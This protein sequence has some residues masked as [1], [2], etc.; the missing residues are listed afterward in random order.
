MSASTPIPLQRLGNGH[1]PQTRSLRLPLHGVPATRWKQLEHLLSSTR[2]DQSVILALITAGFG[3]TDLA[4]HLVDALLEQLQQTQ[5]VSAAWI[6][7]VR[8]ALTDPREVWEPAYLSE[9]ARLRVHLQTHP[10]PLLRG[11]YLALLRPW[12][13]PPRRWQQQW[14][15][16]PASQQTCWP[17]LCEARGEPLTLHRDEALGRLRQQWQ[18]WFGARLSRPLLA[19]CLGRAQ[20][21]NRDEPGVW[22]PLLAIDV[23]REHGGGSS[24][25][26]AVLVRTHL[27]TP[28]PR[29][30]RTNPLVCCLLEIAA[31]ARCDRPDAMCA[32][33]S[34]APMRAAALCGLLLLQPFQPPAMLRQG[35]ARPEP[36]AGLAGGST[37]ERLPP[38]L[39]VPEET[40]VATWPPTAGTQAGALTAA[41]APRRWSA[42]GTVYGAAAV[43]AGPPFVAHRSGGLRP[44]EARTTVAARFTAEVSAHWL[45]VSGSTAADFNA[46]VQSLLHRAGVTIAERVHPDTAVDALFERGDALLANTLQQAEVPLLVHQLLAHASRTTRIYLLAL[47]LSRLFARIQP[48]P[49]DDPAMRQAAQWMVSV[50]AGFRAQ[51]SH[52]EVRASVDTGDAAHWLAPP[53]NNTTSASPL[54][55]AQAID[56]AWDAEFR[57]EPALAWPYGRLQHKHSGR[58]AQPLATADLPTLALADVVLGIA[59]PLLEARQ[60]GYTLHLLP[61]LSA[62]HWQQHCA[63]YAQTQALL[64]APSCL[65]VTWHRVA[66]QL[67]AFAQQLP[68]IDA[69]DASLHLRSRLRGLILPLHRA[70]Q[71][72]E[73]RC[74]HL[75]RHARARRNVRGFLALV[76]RHQRLHAMDATA[77]ADAVHAVLPTPRAALPAVL[78]HLLDH[79]GFPDAEDL[80]ATVERLYA[81]AATRRLLAQLVGVPS[82]RLD[83]AMVHLFFLRLAAAPLGV[84]DRTPTLLQWQRQLTRKAATD[85][86]RGEWIERL[87]P[88]GAAAL[89]ERDDGP[90]LQGLLE[91]ALA[92][93][94]HA[95]HRWALRQQAPQRL[96]AWLESHT[97]RR[98]MADVLGQ[99]GVGLRFL[100]RDRGLPPPLSLRLLQ[101]AVAH[102]LP[103][104]SPDTLASVCARASRSPAPVITLAVMLHTHYPL[105]SALAC[106]THAAVLL[107]DAAP[108]RE[109]P[110]F[111]LRF[112]LPPLPAN[113]SAPALTLQEVFRDCGMPWLE[114]LEPGMP[115]WQ[116]WE[117]LV[118]TAGFQDAAGQLLD[119]V[120]ARPSTMTAL[121][122]QQTV[123]RWLLDHGV[124]HAVVASISAALEGDHASMLDTREILQQQLPALPS[125]MARGVLWWLLVRQAGRPEWCV[126]ELPDGLDYGRSLRSVALLQAVS[127]CEAAVPGAVDALDYSRLV[128]LP[129]RLSPSAAA[130]REDHS[131][132]WLHALVRPALLYAAAHRRITQHGGPARASANETRHA[133]AFVRER[134]AALALAADQLLRPA[135]QRRMLA[136]QQLRDAGVPDP[137]WNRTIEH[138]PVDVLDAAGVTRRPPGATGVGGMSALL[139]A[140]VHAVEDAF[141][142]DTLLEQLV[143]GTV[144]LTGHPS[145]AQLFDQAFALYQQQMTGALAVLL[146]RSLDGLPATDWQMLRGATVTPLLVP[147]AP[148]GIVLR[149]VPPATGQGA[150]SAIHLAVIPS[151]GYAA[152]LRSGDLRVDGQWQSGVLYPHRS[153]VSGTVPARFGPEDHQVLEVARCHSGPKQSVP[154]NGSGD[155]VALLDAMAG[156]MYGDFFIRTRDAELGRLTGGERLQ[157]VEAS[158]ADALARFAIPFYGCGRDLLDGDAA[159]ARVDCTI[160]ALSMMLPEAGLGR[161]LRGTT[162]LVA[163]AGRVSARLLLGD[164]ARVMLRLG[165]DIAAQSGVRLLH[166]LGQGVVRL[167]REGTQWLLDHVPALESRLASTLRHGEE[168]TAGFALDR[169][170]LEETGGHDIVEAGCARVRRQVD[171]GGCTSETITLF[172]YVPAPAFDT[173]GEVGWFAGMQVA[174]DEPLS[175]TGRRFIVDGEFWQQTASHAGYRFTRDSGGTV[176][177]PRQRIRARLVGG[178]SQLVRVELHNPYPDHLLRVEQGAVIGRAD[179]GSRALITRV[180]PGRFYVAPLPAG[181]APLPGQA[182][183][184]WPLEQQGFSAAENDA[185]KTAWWGA[186]HYSQQ[187][188]L[189]GA[190]LVDR[191]GSQLQRQLEQLGDLDRLLQEV[192]AGSPYTFHNLPAQAVMSCAQSNCRYVQALRQQ[193]GP[194]HWRPP[195][196]DD[197]WISD[198]LRDLLNPPG[199]VAR[200]V[201]TTLDDTLEA[202]F[203]TPRRGPAKTLA[204]AE[205]TLQGEP[206]PLVFHATSG[207][208]R[209]K[210]LLPLSNLEQRSAPAGW[211]VDGRNVRTPHARY[212]DAQPSAASITQGEVNT[213]APHHSLH[214]E[215]LDGHLFNERNAR[216]LDAERNLY[217]RI[218]RQITEG[219]LDPTQVT[220]VRLFSSRRIC[221]SC[222]ISVGSLRAR[223][224]EAYFEVVER[225]AGPALD[226]NAAAATQDVA[227]KA[228]LTPRSGRP[229]DAR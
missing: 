11:L 111:V 117:L 172:G 204:M 62:A 129:G 81:R 208:R 1:A 170:L 105:L 125:R 169:R 122:A 20:R 135:P 74:A 163:K 124:G 90:G 108:A 87:S 52:P 130:T 229:A 70:V 142:P 76:H 27:R 184:F 154:A 212:I 187:C 61:Q 220:S 80:E 118:V 102:Y 9:R 92:I 46:G 101:R 10:G 3:G 112:P 19:R 201:F 35:A 45:G 195:R 186:F 137:Y 217:Y 89:F 97:G 160:D 225:Q 205:L 85:V 145:I 47:G 37:T 178:E 77:V 141:N 23:L 221:A 64:D 31:R 150:P 33:E 63:H 107:A 26:E 188:Q 179:D 58:F 192:R 228:P 159:G 181:A 106:L 166:D 2:V 168:R 60:P 175:E 48:R 138:V 54:T 165:E 162:E 119:T 5:P 176:P 134:H 29:T 144:E 202:R 40:D 8:Q 69:S 15:G 218:E 139:D 155:P 67:Q 147:G 68:L 93:P 42:M 146:A 34:P 65:L 190:A 153:F 211:E 72:L 100:F 113:F 164:A 43:P 149:C 120:A 12:S 200:D 99:P 98:R 185:V 128:Q 56:D 194:A 222:H 161:L 214:A 133:L 25:M 49:L 78:S 182:L 88:A 171:I 209:G 66:R 79:S 28:S 44:E 116:A 213:V 82:D 13:L 16:L 177:Q 132:A 207:Q 32:L 14:S 50:E 140:A 115:P 167:G 39:D 24:G 30:Q 152:R 131:A 123:A 226:I 6:G 193:I 114:Q 227:A 94:D 203:L 86:L 83:S 21:L 219:A 189:S 121:T 73:G 158:V 126:A 59:H 180:S 127:L 156:M 223:F 174:S 151:A 191:F 173:P 183:E 143:D 91:D 4:R 199:T 136:A 196:P 197:V 51:V 57:P 148:H 109:I 38:S 103:D 206:V 216:R 157:Q 84:S 55:C 17:A 7:L 95:P 215:D 22:E 198:A 104:T 41:G 71:S 224:P 110:A 18:D 75:P 210:G 96:Q 36:R 53:A